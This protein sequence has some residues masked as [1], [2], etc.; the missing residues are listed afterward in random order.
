MRLDVAQYLVQDVQFADQLAWEQGTLT[1]QPEQLRTLF[2]QEPHIHDVALHIVRPGESARII[3]VLD[4]VGPMAK[5]E[6]P[7][8][9]FPGFLGPPLTCG[10]GRTHQLLGFNLVQSAILPE[11]QH[12]VLSVREGI[13]DM[14]GPAAPYCAAAESINLVAVCTPAPHATNVEFDAAI[15]RSSLRVAQALAEVTRSVSPDDVRRYELASCHA[16]L[17]AVV[18]IAQVR[19]QGPLV[20]SFLYGHHLENFVPTLIHPNELLDGALVSGNYTNAF[21]IPTY[22]RC[23]DPVLDSLMRRHGQDLRLLG[24]ILTRGHCPGAFEK[25]RNAHYGA[26]LAQLLGA[27][28][29]VLTTEGIGNGMIEFMQTMQACEQLGIQT[30]AIVL[31]SGGDEPPVLGHVPEADALVSTGGMAETLTLPAVER[32]FGGETVDFF[33]GAVVDAHSRVTLTPMELYAS[34]WKMGCSGITALDY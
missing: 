12:G 3:H 33:T 30:V 15:R 27:E 21:K 16:D 17:P 25:E 19:Q 29:A 8:T 23:R 7:S 10:R 31:E 26:K 5:V 6:G 11:P 32:V 22:G 28:G 2:C 13:I 14:S 24:V 9:V 18:Y 20:Q 34:A 1:I 4:T